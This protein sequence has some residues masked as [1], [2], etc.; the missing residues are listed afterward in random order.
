MVHTH[1][2]GNIARQSLNH[3]AGVVT[4]FLFAAAFVTFIYVGCGVSE[5][6]AQQ[7]AEQLRLNA[8]RQVTLT[9]RSRYPQVRLRTYTLICDDDLDRRKVESEAVMQIKVELPRAVQTKEADRFERIL[10]R[11]FVFR[12]EDEFYGRADYIRARVNNKDT[13]MTAD[14]DNVVLHFLGDMAL[15]TYRNTVVI[16][17]GG[18]E[19]TVRMTW[20]DILAK[21]DGQWKFRAV[22]LIDSK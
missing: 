10:A 22:Y 6:I 8:P 14:Y 11:A 5:S 13:V 4:R 19:H 15:L 9:T 16:E 20:A 18:P 3:F 7:H 17:P 1:R 2:I 12:G 21:E